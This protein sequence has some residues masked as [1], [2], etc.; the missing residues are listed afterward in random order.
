MVPAHWPDASPRPRCDR[1]T[2]TG[3]PSRSGRCPDGGCLR[4]GLSRLGHSPN[5]HHNVRVPRLQVVL[6]RHQRAVTEPL[7]D[8]EG[9]QGALTA[10]SRS[11]GCG[12]VWE[13]RGVTPQGLG[14]YP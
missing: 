11:G 6:R 3:T 7:G 5:R 10:R 12:I 4:L 2:G 13:W 8:H 9:G 14:A 1:V